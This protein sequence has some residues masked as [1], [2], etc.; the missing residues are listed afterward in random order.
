ML[1]RLFAGGSLPTLE[2]LL[3]YAS[4]RQKVIAA[5][6]ANVDTLGYRTRDLAAPDFRSALDRLLRVGPAAE[7][8]HEPRRDL[9]SVSAAQIDDP[10][11]FELAIRPGDGVRADH[12]LLRERA[13]GRQRVAGLQSACPDRVLHLLHQL[14]IDRDA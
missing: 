13:D 8:L 11:V 4:A 6:I 14:Q 1:N 5:N 10:F 9:C 3:S 7:S 2:A 12:E